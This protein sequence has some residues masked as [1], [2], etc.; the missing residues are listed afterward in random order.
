MFRS[1]RGAPWLEVI[2]GQLQHTKLVD[3]KFSPQI[4][5]KQH[6]RDGRQH[7]AATVCDPLVLQDSPKTI[8]FPTI[9]SYGRG[10][11]MRHPAYQRSPGHWHPRIAPLSQFA[12]EPA[13][14]GR[15]AT[16]A[17]PSCER[18]KSHVCMYINHIYRHKKAISIYECICT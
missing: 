4:G 1:V 2:Q 3:S 6:R 11:A 16:N 13:G 15:C 8:T 14:S 18:I 7:P 5:H 17:T 9:S 12:G 10:K